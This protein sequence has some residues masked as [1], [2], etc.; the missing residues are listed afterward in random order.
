MN[1]ITEITKR[2]ISQC[3]IEGIEA[4]GIF[5]SHK[6]IYPYFGRVDELTFLN[7][8]YNLKEIPSLDSRYKNSE[9]EIRQHTI[10]RGN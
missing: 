7:K 3:F 6:E 8:L 1:L 4:P 10:K 2:D 9:D 5:E